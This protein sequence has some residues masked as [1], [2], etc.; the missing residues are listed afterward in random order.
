MTVGVA[1]GAVGTELV[2][3]LHRLIVEVLPVYDEHHFIYSLYLCGE[4]RRLEGGERLARPRSVP[5][6]A[7]S[8]PCALPVVEK[9]LLDALDDALGGCYLVGSH[10]EQFLVGVE[11]AVFSQDVEQGALGKEGLG[12]VLQV[13]DKV[14]LSIAPVTGKLEG[15]ALRLLL[16]PLLVSLLLTSISGGVAVILGLRAVGDDEELYVVEH[17]LASP[18]ALSGVAVYLVEGFLDAHAPAFQFN[19][20]QRQTVH[21]DAYIVTVVV[22]A[23]IGH[24]LVDYLQAVLEHVV[25]V[26]QVDVGLRAVVTFYLDGSVGSLNHVGL[27]FQGERVVGYFLQ[28][29]APFLVGEH[30][31]IHLAQ[32][33]T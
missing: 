3:L 23:A 2:V 24:V 33:L 28:Q 21:Q 1:V 4:L 27:V 15:V 16:A 8:L 29:V 18:E 19:V 12:K 22:G 30:D 7:S 6:V 13:A 9:C 25:L 11:H 10:H 20:D 31:V 14:V 5:D 32:L 17:S 26:Q